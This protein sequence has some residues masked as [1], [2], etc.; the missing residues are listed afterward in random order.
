MASE[1][2]GDKPESTLDARGQMVLEL[3]G[4]KYVLRPSFEAQ[5]AI[6][7]KLRPIASL[8][9]EAER[10]ALSLHEMGVIVCEFMRAQGKASPDDPLAG[11][12]Q[13][14]NPTRCSELIF[15]AGSMA[16]CM[17]LYLVLLGAVT[18][19][20]DAKGELKATTAKK[21]S[22]PAVA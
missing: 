21:T 2:K 22:T 1:K 8:A 17:K 9:A 6:E 19:G 14:A 12:Y 16:V 4:Q 15:E 13:G 3:G 5:L 18:G 7:S 10:N 11:D 20:Y